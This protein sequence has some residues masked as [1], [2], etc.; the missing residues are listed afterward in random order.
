[1]TVL[2]RSALVSPGSVSSFAPTSMR[3]IDSGSSTGIDSG[4]PALVVAVRNASTTSDQ[5]SSWLARCRL[6]RS[7]SSS[8][9]KYSY[10]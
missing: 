9:M 6:V 7:K 1:M 3:V 4:R 5:P 10:V 2:N 8:A